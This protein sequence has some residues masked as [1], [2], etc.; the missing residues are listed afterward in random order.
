[1]DSQK[2]ALL[3]SILVIFLVFAAAVFLYQ[4]AQREIAAANLIRPRI[5]NTMAERIKIVSDIE[6]LNYE[7]DQ[8][9][10]QLGD[11]SSKIQGYEAE[12]PKVKSERD[13]IAVRMSKVEEELFSLDRSLAAVSA[14]ETLLKDKLASSQAEYQDLLD[15]VEYIAKEKSSLEQQLKDYIQQ[16][17][18]VELRK[19]VV[20]VARPL[21]GSVVEVSRKYNFAVID[22]GEADG[23]KSGDVVEIYRNSRLVAKALVENV[24]DVMSSIVV[25]DEWRNV[26]LFIGDSIRAQR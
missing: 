14:Q 20:K 16:S 3:V 8:L 9:T 25:F 10:V 22:I 26:E 24:Y 12:I 7:K 1:M 18:G 5:D 13:D 4:D 21:E 23:I 2:Q 11:Y 6:S 17:K 15:A 19:V